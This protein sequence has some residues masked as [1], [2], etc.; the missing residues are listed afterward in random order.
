MCWN[1]LAYASTGVPVTHRPQ[2]FTFF[3]LY[4]QGQLKSAGVSSAD[5]AHTLAKLEHNV[6]AY[7]GIHRHYVPVTNRHQPFAF[8]LPKLY[9]QIQLKSMLLYKVGIFL[10]FIYN[11]YWQNAGQKPAHYVPEFT[12]IHR[13]CVPVTN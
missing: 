10:Q 13:H 1:T 9:L 2:P 6:P 3:Q 11:Y 7:T 5:S 4:I 12:G 8:F